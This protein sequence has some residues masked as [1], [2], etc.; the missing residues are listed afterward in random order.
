MQQQ[1]TLDPRIDIR[2][3][4]TDTEVL[5][6]V[7]R[8]SVVMS[9]KEVID[10]FPPSQRSVCHHPV[11]GT[12]LNFFEVGGGYGVQGV[13]VWIISFEVAQEVD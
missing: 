3:I 10:F 8:T 6:A 13:P 9:A 5:N 1:T 12:Y 11:K 2:W 4:Q 7:S